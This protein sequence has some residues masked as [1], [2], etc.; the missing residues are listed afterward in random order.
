[1]AAPALVCAAVEVALNRYLRLE[2]SVIAD[3]A[4]LEGKSIALEAADLGW[5]FVIEP[6]ATG[7]RVS[8]VAEDEPDVL[9]SAPTLRLARLGLN[10]LA[11]REG[12]P[13]G[14]EVVGDT[15]L[16]NRFNGLL[17]RVG[18]DPEELV[19]KVIGDGAAHRLVGGLRGLF[20][21]GRSAADKLSRDTAEYL[22]EES[23]D[24]AR[25]ADVEEWMDAVDLLREDT[26]RLE[27][28][29]AQLESR[30]AA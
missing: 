25:V 22:T 6:I 27:A 10:T 11:R 15:E 3:C 2:R 13:T 19:A 20:G 24:L 17:T 4:A 8:N 30:S 5:M 21:F 12:L 29:L 23:E 16:L 9:V 28:R 14:I 18:F 7:V 26:D 1:M